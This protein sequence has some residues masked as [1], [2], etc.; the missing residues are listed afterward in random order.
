MQ[1][2]LE[3]R[4]NKEVKQPK[5]QKHNKGPHPE[6]ASS[7]RCSIC[8]E[9]EPHNAK[10]CPKR[11]EVAEKRS[12]KPEKKGKTKPR[13]STKKVVEDEDE[14][15]FQDE[16]EDDEEESEDLIEEEEEEE[17]EEEEEEQEE[18]EKVH[19]N[20]PQAA[21]PRRSARLMNN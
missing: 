8:K 12:Q 20:K 17:D 15:D 10:T 3:R 4:D 16:V 1:T 6:K 9:Y 5:P 19:D 21:K 2:L 13:A 11:I 14:Q 7:R 18:K